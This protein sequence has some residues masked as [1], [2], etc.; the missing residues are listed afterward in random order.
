MNKKRNFHFSLNLQFSIVVLGSIIVGIMAVVFMMT[1]FQPFATKKI[2]PFMEE[3]NQEAMEIIDQENALTVNGPLVLDDQMRN[4]NLQAIFDAHPNFDFKVDYHQGLTAEK[5]D[6]YGIKNRRENWFETVYIPTTDGGLI[7][8]MGNP[9]VFRFVVIMILGI[10]VFSIAVTL[11][12]I[13]IFVSRKSQYIKKIT[14]LLEV[15]EGG[16][17]T[18]HIPVKGFDEMS[19]LAK[20]INQMTYSLNEQQNQQKASEEMK[21][22]LIAN[23]SHDLRTPLT[24][25]L[26]YLS[27]LD[28]KE[29]VLTKENYEEYIH[30]AYDRTQHVAHLVDQLFNYVLI[31]NHQIQCKIERVNP[32]VI[33][34]QLVTESDVITHEMHLTL[35]LALEPSRKNCEMDVMLCQRLIDNLF[36][37]VQKYATKESTVT[38]KGIS[39]NGFYSVVIVNDTDQTF[40]GST[41]NF[42][43]RYYTSDRVSGKSAGLGLAICNEIMQ[44]QGGHFYANYIDRQFSVIIDFKEVE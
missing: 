41:E 22:Q 19:Q 18:T 38:I 10:S 26:G 16:D 1:L 21:K 5:Y 14:N 28:Q 34:G 40:E 29:M 32:E 31:A 12:L 39:R 36:S 17:L 30:K 20:H 8:T 2:T 33:I 13:G 23:I 35:K 7:V 15:I 42:M 25:V 27:I 43:E 11:T 3:L 6:E 4:A 24:A 37:N 9:S 44:I